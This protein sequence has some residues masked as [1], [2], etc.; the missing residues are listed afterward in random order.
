MQRLFF[1]KKKK[2]KFSLNLYNITYKNLFYCTDTYSNYQINV[3]YRMWPVRESDGAL[4][5]VWPLQG[6]AEGLSGSAGT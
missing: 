6:I 1:E 4:V 5:P 2:K 3:S